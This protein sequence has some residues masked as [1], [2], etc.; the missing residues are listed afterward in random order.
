MTRVERFAYVPHTAHQMYE[1]VRAVGDYPIFLSW[2]TGADV[3][4]HDGD[5][6]EASLEIS[7]AGIRQKFTT[8]NTHQ[9]GEQIRIELLEG[10]FHSLAGIWRFRDMADMG[11]KVSVEL[12]F[13]FNN[14]LLGAAFARGFALVADRLVDDF[15]KRAEVVYGNS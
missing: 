6:M 14:R 9:N 1:L 4:R 8:R 7:V 2:C 5:I 13:E 12:D 11:S 15:C 10:P 3:I